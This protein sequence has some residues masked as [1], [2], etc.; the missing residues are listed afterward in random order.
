M[1]YFLIFLFSLLIQTLP[2]DLSSQKL[3]K[4]LKDAAND[5]S[6]TLGDALADKAIEKLADKIVAKFDNSIDS[7][8]RDEYER[9]S[10]YQ[11]KTY[12]D[13]LSDYDKSSELPESY[14]FT[15]NVVYESVNEKGKKTKG[16]YR[17][18]SDEKVMGIETENAL[19]VFDGNNNLMVNYNLEDKEGYATSDRFLKLGAALVTDEMVPDYNFEKTGEYKTILGYRCQKIVGSSQEGESISAF[20]AEDF[21]VTLATLNNSI[22]G[23][24]GSTKFNQLMVDFNGMS[25]ESEIIEKD[26]GRMDT[27]VTEVSKTTYSLKTSEFNFGNN[28][29]KN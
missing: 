16:A 27:K 12:S 15:L 10:S 8:F 3:G 22:F 25:L 19:I 17:F 5:I 21:P 24:Q 13:F 2:T 28:S 11:S 6:T 18:T 4:L 1:K 29:T 9:D 26:G 14:D 7:L 20:I 23:E